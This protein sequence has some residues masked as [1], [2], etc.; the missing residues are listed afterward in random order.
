TTRRIVV[1]YNPEQ[2]EVV[3]LCAITP[4]IEDQAGAIEGTD[5]RIDSFV[6]GEIAYV[7]QNADKAVVNSIKFRVKTNGHSKVR[8]VIE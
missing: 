4:E 6:P 5:M 2:L 7:V 8:Y 1:Y 3:D